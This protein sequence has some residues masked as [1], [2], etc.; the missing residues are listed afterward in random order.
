MFGG[1]GGA[2]GDVVGVAVTFLQPGHA[3]TLA[4]KRRQALDREQPES[5]APPLEVDLERGVVRLLPA[6]PGAHER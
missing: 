2:F 5:G 3:H 4:E 1:R 6:D